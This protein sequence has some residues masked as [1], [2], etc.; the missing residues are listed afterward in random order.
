MMSNDE[1]ETY[2]PPDKRNRPSVSRVAFQPAAQKRANPSID[3]LIQ[4]SIALISEENLRQ[5]VQHL[6]AYKTRHTLS[7]YIDQVATWLVDQF[8][9]F[10]YTDVVLHPYSRNGHALNNVVCTKQGSSDGDQVLMLCGH[11]D[12]CMEQLHDATARA[13]GADDNATGIAVILE[14]A[15]ILSSI[16]LKQTVQFV[17]FSGEEQGYWGSAAYADSIQNQQINLHRLINL[18]MLGYPPP[19]LAITVEQDKGNQVADNDQPSQEFARVMAQLATDYTQLPVVMGEVYGSDYMP[20]EARGYVV[21]GLYDDGNNPNYHRSS[22]TPNTVNYA[23]MADVARIVLATVLNE[24]AEHITSAAY[25][26]NSVTLR[27]F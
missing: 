8:R 1:L 12:C 27:G 18:D 17:A 3:P 16:D 20:F 13:P 14:L 23:Y 9:S 6:S 15:R 2:P 25:R 7:V 5:W 10:G 4:E 21:V 22:D 26:S 11:Y 24:T 19:N